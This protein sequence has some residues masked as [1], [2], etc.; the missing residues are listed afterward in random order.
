MQEAKVLN[1]RLDN[2]LVSLSP[3]APRVAD[4]TAS[5]QNVSKELSDNPCNLFVKKRQP[6]TTHILIMVVSEDSQN[7]KPHALPVQYVPYNTI[8]DQYLRNLSKCEIR[9]H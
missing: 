4:V 8:W 6:P 7:K 3:S 2:S 9:D 5:L 1:S